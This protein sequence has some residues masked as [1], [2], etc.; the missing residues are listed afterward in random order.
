MSV[1]GKVTKLMAFVVAVICVLVAG[2][3]VKY[4]PQLNDAQIKR[5]VV[6]ETVR[7]YKAEVTVTEVQAG[8]LLQNEFDETETIESKGLLIALTFAMAA[9]EEEQRLSPKSLH[10]DGDRVYEAIE[11]ASMTVPAGFRGTSIFVYEVDPNHIDD[12]WIEAG[13]GEIFY[14][15]PQE[16]RIRLGI[17]SANADQ[18]RRA[19]RGRT[20]TSL[21]NPEL[22]ALP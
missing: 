16:L 18:W 22:Q 4:T 15:Y 10:A 1:Q 20:V 3:A 8:T 13:A 7:F 2:V 6:G 5:A 17:T 9:P 11:S 12:L 21:A 19:A 14:A